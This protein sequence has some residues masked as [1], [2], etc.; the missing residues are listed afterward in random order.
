MRDRGKELHEKALKK[1]I[2]EQSKKDDVKIINLKGKSPDG[3]MAKIDKNGSIKLMAVEVLPLGSN[4]RIT[5]KINNYDMFD[6][7]IIVKYTKKSNMKYKIKELPEMNI[8]NPYTCHR[9]KEKF[10]DKTALHS[11]IYHEHLSKDIILEIE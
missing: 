9:C 11:H 6:E 7:T 10:P 1:Y 3:I 5:E 2:E 4:Y 8:D